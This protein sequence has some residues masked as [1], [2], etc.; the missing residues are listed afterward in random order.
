MDRQIG[1][2]RSSRFVGC[3][4]DS[5]KPALKKQ[6]S[7]EKIKAE[8]STTTAPLQRA[9]SQT[10]LGRSVCATQTFFGNIKRLEEVVCYRTMPIN[11]P[12]VAIFFYTSFSKR[13]ILI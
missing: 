3:F 7:F 2:G 13:T 8:A 10:R 5:T 9:F 6:N 1:Y 11:F 4:N 12:L